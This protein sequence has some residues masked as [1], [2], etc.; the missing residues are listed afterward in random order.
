MFDITNSVDFYAKLLAEFDDF[1]DDQASARHAMNCAITAHHMYDWIWVDFLKD[2]DALR[3]K[4]GIGGKKSDFAAWAAA[5]LPW[6]AVVQGISN[7]SKHFIRQYDQSIEQVAGYGVGG[8]G[9]GTYG[10]SY[11][12]IDM[13]TEDARYLPLS[14][15]FEIVV[16]FWRDFFRECGKGDQLA[17][18][19]TPLSS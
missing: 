15:V 18:G 7:G 13:R 2:D 3:R 8:Y 16:H 4:L 19:R 6:F 1:M 17:V 9:Q 12:A 11:L 5:R 14:F 10:A